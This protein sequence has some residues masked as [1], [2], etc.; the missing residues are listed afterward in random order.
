MPE[1]LDRTPINLKTSVRRY[2]EIKLKIIPS[3]TV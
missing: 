2:E 1:D 3:L